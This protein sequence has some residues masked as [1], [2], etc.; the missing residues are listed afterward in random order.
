MRAFVFISFVVFGFLA[1]M[2]FTTTTPTLID[3]ASPS[4]EQKPIY[5]VNADARSVIATAV[6]QA[7]KDNKH[8]LITWGGN[9]CGWCTRLHNTIEENG[10]IKAFLQK[11]FVRITVDSRSNKD[12]MN[13]MKVDPPGVPYMTVLNG[14][15]D[16]VA[17]QRSGTLVVEGK[18]QPAKIMAFLEK[19]D[20][21]AE[22]TSAIRDAESKLESAL[23]KLDR[24]D[25]RLFVKF[26][27]ETCGWCRR[28]DSFLDGDGIKPILSKDFSFIEMDQGTLEG[29]KELRAR[30]SANRPSGGVP[31]FAVLNKDGEVL[32][33][34]TGPNGNI[35]YPAE[36]EGIVHFMSIIGQT[37][38]TINA[39]ERD[40]VETKLKELAKSYGY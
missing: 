33:T 22:K 9:W 40:I 15:G 39:N 32:A 6:E 31:W 26:S 28:L 36:P 34:A 23:A 13:E 38:A 37:G 35:G 27:T 29:A 1:S 20:Q 24:D 8:V 10:E 25:K 17:D 18:H 19:Y 7:K 3:A 5:D 4:A 12:L 11:N 30:L 2:L 14:D 21:N 16:K